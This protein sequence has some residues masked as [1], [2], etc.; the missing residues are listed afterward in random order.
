MHHHSRHKEIFTPTVQGP[1]DRL[2]IGL[3][4]ASLASVAS[5]QLVVNEFDYDQ[6]STDTAEF[7][8]IKNTSAGNV[9]LSGYSLVLVNGATGVVYDTIALPAV[10]L[11]AGDFYVV[12]ANAATVAN[13][14]L[15]DGPNTDFIQNGAPDAI[16]ILQA[17]TVIDAV[18]YEGNTIAPYTEGSGVGLVDDPAVTNSGLSRVP[19]GTDSN[20]NN[21]DFTPCPITPGAAN[22]CGSVDVA[23]EVASTS[24]VNG[25]TGVDVA[26][27]ISITFN[28]AVNVSGAWFSIAC[29]SSGN[30]TALVTGGPTSFT[31]DPDSDFVLAEVCTVDVFA[32]QV[33][34]VDGDD[35]PDTMADD[36]LF[37][38][39]TNPAAVA[40]LVINEVDY[41]Q[42]G[43]DAAEFV[44]IMNA[45]TDPV[46]LSGYSLRFINGNAGGSAVY[47]TI[48]LPVVSLAA[49][50]FFVVCADPS[51]TPHC[52]LDDGPDTNFIQNGDPDAVALLQGANLV[53]TLS[54]GGNTAAPYTEGSGAGLDDPSGAGTD[55]L[56]LSRLP[57]G[58]D[59]NVN[60]VDFSLRCITPGKPNASA[61]TDC[62][63]PRPPALR[64]NEID[65][66]Q[67]GTD[68]AE[69]VEIVNAGQSAADLS[70]VSL[71]LVNGNAGGAVIYQTI[72]LPPV[73]L[74]PLEH[75]VVCANVA[76]VPNCDL[77]GFSSVQNGS[78]DAVALEQ[79][80]VLLDAVS[81][82]GDTGA[83]YTEGSGAGLVDS[84]SAGQDH[85]G[86]GRFP[87]GADT[88]QNNIDLS[89]ACIT[90]GFANTSL[91]TDC[92]AGGPVLEVFT[93]QG[94]GSASGFAGQG[95]A[96]LD[97]IVTVVGPEGF[98]M[99]TPDARADADDNTS[100][101]IYVFTGAA[102]AVAV[103]DQVDVAGQ[104]VE[105]F[106]FTEFAS[107][108]VVDVDSSGNPLPAA[109]VF[110]ASVPSPDPLAPSCTIEFECYESMLISIEG[111]AVTGPNQFFGSDPVAEVYI[112][113]AATRTF[114]EPGVEFPGLPG[115]PEWD[116]NPEVFE[117][118][119]DK[120]GLPN[121]HIPAGSG[122]DA[123]GVLGYEFG[124]YELW[125][126]SLDLAP[127]ALP[128]AVRARANAEMTVGALNLFRLFDDVD[129]APIEVRDPDTNALLRTTD[130]EVFSTAEYQRRLAKFST[131]IRGVLDAPDVLAVS[132]VESLKVLQ[133]LATVIAA[134]EPTIVYTAW[135]EEGNDIGGI[136][137][138]FLTRDTVA[139]DLVSQLG[140]FELLSSDGSLLNDRPALLL[141]GRQVADGSDFPIAVMALHGRSL[142][143]I[144]DPVDGERVR[145]K[146]YEQAQS[147]A[148]KVQA[149][150]DA[151]PD[152]NLVLA[153]DFNAFEFS[154]G[155]VDVTGIMAGAFT[156]AD[157]LACASNPC[158]DQV[159]P[160][161][162]DQVTLIPAGER[163]SYIFDGNAQV[164]DHALTSSGLDELVRDF[165]YGRA[166]AD[167]AENLISD[168]STPLR[169]SDHDGLV[170]FLAKD[171]DGD[172]VTDDADLCPATAI[173]E[174]APW[175]SLGN[176]R[177]A[178]T[179]DDRVFDT[180]K[181]S[182]LSFDIFDTAG[183]SC[184][185]IVAAQGLGEGQLKYGCSNGV[186]EDWVEE[187]GTP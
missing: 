47:D 64:I 146:R 165:S 117:L 31:L 155:F 148:A 140:R 96:T 1:W 82:G 120:L 141:E 41:D 158:E 118:D 151:D 99:Q 145:Q 36:Y 25:A 170:L 43:T 164:L 163:Y 2:L 129:D 135:L 168:E 38:F 80:G 63:D 127:A 174:S 78:P 60:N 114:R 124:G 126:V 89:N 90:P 138:G 160:D 162:I 122:F 179:N 166:N 100:N 54:Y 52:D 109:I 19:D 23:P 27:N 3:L 22:S 32:A 87:D 13:C 172:G 101:G 142:S 119:A 125:P 111:G 128:V 104:V 28:E 57:D 24:P 113:A 153:G 98:F 177:W 26:D 184:E 157:N 5:A 152:I 115:L 123:V 147:V 91:T 12:C 178:L 69:F 74:P 55:Y 37:F 17:A 167:A 112:T 35:P 72:A 150:Q 75:F 85:R 71:L 6:V 56:G 53:D 93:I 16:A 39:D 70:G 180:G 187:A 130:D 20:V 46:E 50:D 14:D 21:V 68:T 77:A 15:D 132:E 10:N 76:N 11:A 73:M 48:A 49:G 94:A 137:V 97:N 86:I 79:D 171:S 181:A 186:M 4:L 176:G 133:D 67:P 33:T 88:G 95:V 183:C 7:V 59:S 161:L 144:D 169:S 105:F 34:D 18:S 116:G 9:D 108:A 84:G 185:Q 159:S 136:D 131:Y 30:H 40:T 182:D 65:Y 173:P 139:V 143:A 81:Y 92:S 156:P 103:G 8:E 121:P 175:D 102:P 83:P 58:S 62:P 149:L 44:E 61:S 29:D 154:D 51:N 66:D 45:G 106:D 107:G 134:E 42:P 110:D